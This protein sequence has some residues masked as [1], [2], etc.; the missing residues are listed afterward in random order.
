MRFSYCFR[1]IF[2]KVVGKRHKKHTNTHTHVQRCKNAAAG[3]VAILHTPSLG[4]GLL[5]LGEISGVYGL[6]PQLV[7]G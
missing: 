6:C 4:G 3:A 5:A 7:H 1:T 2:D